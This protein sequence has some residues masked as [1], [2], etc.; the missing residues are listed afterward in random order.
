[1]SVQ[2][3]IEAA[4]V[5][6]QRDLVL[7]YDKL[8]LRASGKWANELENFYNETGTG[9]RF[10]ILGAQYTDVLQN[11]R[12]KN[13][14]QTKE[15]LRAWVG[16]AGSTFLKD[17]VEQ[18]GIQVSPFAVAWK[19]AREGVKV[20]N[21]FNSGGLVSDVINDEAIEKFAEI[22]RFSIIESVSSDVKNVLTNG[23]N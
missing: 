12:R 9:Y 18:K 22:I 5:D 13:T 15:S 20:P 23:N 1:M 8:G 11:G 16:W 4:L 14:K 17:W 3:R 6:L 10:G 2:T 19:I 21:A 7:N